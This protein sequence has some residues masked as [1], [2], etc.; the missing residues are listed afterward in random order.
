MQGTEV[1]LTSGA[2]MIH[3]ILGMDVD[4]KRAMSEW[5][6][7]SLGARASKIKFVYQKAEATLEIIDDGIGCPDL[8][9]MESLA[10]SDK[11]VGNKASMYGIGGLLGQIKLSQAG[12]VHVH[13]ITSSNDSRMQIDWGEC[14]KQNRLVALHHV[15]TPTP[16]TKTKTSIKIHSCRPIK[17]GQP[18]DRLIRELG[19]RYSHEI[20]NGKAIVFDMDGVKT[21]VRPYEHPPFAD[22]V[23]LDFEVEGHHITGFC[24]LVLPGN[25]NPFPGWSI[26]WGY[27]FLDQ[28]ADPAVLL[29]LPYGRIYSEVFLPESWKN[30]GVTKDKFRDDADP[31]W[32]ALAERCSDLIKAGEEQAQDFELLNSARSVDKLLAGVFS[33]PQRVKGRRPGEHVQEGAVDPSGNGSPHRRFTTTQPGDKALQDDDSL[34]STPPDHVRI[35]WDKNMEEDVLYRVATGAGKR[36]MIVTLNASSPHLLKFRDDYEHLACLCLTFIAHEMTTGGD[37]Y[38]NMFPEFYRE[39]FKEIYRN[40]LSRLPFKDVPATPTNGTLAHQPA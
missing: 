40:L 34:P 13:S 36:T 10:V 24:G 3:V 14:L 23:P 2:S 26:H 20:R 37:E 5:I 39:P 32:N 16:G 35:H 12:L 22:E 30:I 17:Q 4:W 21:K 38:R 27:R 29:G 8:Q 1:E 25:P 9:V 28:F 6:D 18:F 11:V 7:N 19:Y 15:K 33:G 31:L